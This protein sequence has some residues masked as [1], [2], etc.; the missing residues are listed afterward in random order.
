MDL[1]KVLVEA[2]A[3]I[4]PIDSYYSTPLMQAYENKKDDVAEY[5]I[6]KGAD[7]NH[8]NLDGYSVFELK[9]R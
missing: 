1:V 3:N 4:D 6:S 7:V 5:L 9:R 8:E 2:G